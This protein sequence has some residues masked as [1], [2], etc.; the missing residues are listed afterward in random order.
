MSESVKP[1]HEPVDAASGEQASGEQASREQASG[2]NGT[3]IFRNILVALDSSV[4]SKAALETAAHMAERF[5]SGLKGLFVHEP[6]WTHRSKLTRSLRID[7]PAGEVKVMA[8]E[9][10]EMEMQSQEREVESHFRRVT[11]RRGV[12]AE[13]RVE[14]GAVKERMQEAAGEVDLVTMGVSGVSHLKTRKLGSTAMAMI[15]ECGK[16][17]MLLQEGLDLSG[18]IVAVYDGTP[19]GLAVVEMG[20]RVAKRHGGTFFVIHFGEAHERELRE[21]LDDLFSDLKVLPRFYQIPERDY[22]SYLYLLNR[23][24]SG[25]LIVPKS[26]R[27]AKREHLLRILDAAHCPVMLM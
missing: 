3:H 19:D 20:A 23:M 24:R 17:V 18:D 4:H 8:E 6:G 7:H 13:W 22:G 1:T 12:P 10:V 25:L 9:T 2:D 11:E 16:P 15:E 26:S 27:M 14:K 21:K 5:R